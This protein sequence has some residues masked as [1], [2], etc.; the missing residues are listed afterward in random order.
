MT[1]I[2]FTR[3]LKAFFD[4]H[5]L[6]HL[7]TFGGHD[8]GCRVAM[9]A[10]DEYD[11]QSPWDNAQLLGEKLLKDLKSLAGRNTA[12]RSVSGKGLLISLKLES[13][14]AALNFCR[15][16][17]EKGLLVNAGK[18]DESCVVLRPSLLIGQAEETF[19]ADTIAGI[20]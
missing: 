19:I 8:L 18:I 15:K 7:C 14:E 3:E 12:L 13:K 16:A 11:R 6:I 17:R 9:E 2:I 5:P 20:I 4:M 1:A 10:L